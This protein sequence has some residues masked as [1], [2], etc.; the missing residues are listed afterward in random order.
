M[1]ETVGLTATSTL[2]N[3]EFELLKLIVLELRVISLY[4][5]EGLGH[6]DEPSVLR[7]ALAK[8][9]EVVVS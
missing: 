5:K 7:Q 4:L 6:T 1:A 2:P 3:D 9:T 8:Q